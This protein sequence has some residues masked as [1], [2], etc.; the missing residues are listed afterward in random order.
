MFHIVPLLAAGWRPSF[1][2]IPHGPIIA[3]SQTLA[4][5][6]VRQ[7]KVETNGK[8]LRPT[9]DLQRL[10]R[11]RPDQILLLAA[12]WRA[13]CF[14]VPHGP[15]IGCWVTPKLFPYSTWSHYWR[16]GGGQV[17]S[18]FHMVP[19]LAADGGHIVSMHIDCTIYFLV[20]LAPVIFRSMTM[21]WLLQFHCI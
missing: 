16:L 4:Q 18:I 12:G 7:A 15:I 20:V 3:H 19:F 10:T 5:G 21:L 8:G 9:T 17:V 14:N 2:H 1:F 13:S 6:H 11:S